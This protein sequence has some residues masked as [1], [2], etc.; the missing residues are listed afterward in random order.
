MRSIPCQCL[1]VFFGKKIR[2]Q[3]LKV[4]FG[5]KIRPSFLGSAE[6]KITRAGNPGLNIID[7]LYRFPSLGFFSQILQTQSMEAFVVNYPL[8]MLMATWNFPGN[9]FNTSETTA[10]RASCACSISLVKSRE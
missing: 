6:K 9:R 7:M 4:F 2:P 3:C 5:K 10:S 8:Y 1:K